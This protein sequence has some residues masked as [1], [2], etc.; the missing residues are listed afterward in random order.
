MYDISRMNRCFCLDSNNSI[1]PSISKAPAEEHLLKW[2]LKFWSG[3]KIG[4]LVSVCV[5][6]C[7]WVCV[8]WVTS[9]HLVLALWSQACFLFF[10]LLCLASCSHHLE[11]GFENQAKSLPPEWH[12]NIPTYTQPS[13]RSLSSQPHTTSKDNTVGVLN[14]IQRDLMGHWRHKMWLLRV[15]IYLKV[16]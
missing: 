15:T 14:G 2:S 13:C 7:Q 12:E 3:C 10:L 5:C 8:I 16:H 11:A 4:C 1:S 6:V 9:S